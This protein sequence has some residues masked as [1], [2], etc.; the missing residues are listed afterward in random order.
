MKKRVILLFFLFFCAFL[1]WGIDTPYFM[2]NLNTGYSVGVNIADGIQYNMNLFYPGERVGLAVE[3]GV[4]NIENSN[5]FHFFAGPMIFLY[6]SVKWRVPLALGLDILGGDNSAYHGIGC[7]MS[8]QYVMSSNF[9]LG[10][11]LGF[12]YLLN[13]LFPVQTGTRQVSSLSADGTIVTQTTPV[14]ENK[15]HIGTR[16]HIRPSILIGFQY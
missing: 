5:F 15:N 7:L 10:I 2:I 3:I 8:A 6:N 9:Y 16:F 1:T 12:S 14:L 4:L 13:N 11:N